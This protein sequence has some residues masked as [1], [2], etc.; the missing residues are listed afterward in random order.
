MLTSTD[1]STLAA[2]YHMVPCTLYSLGSEIG[3]LGQEHGVLP[4]FCRW[5][6]PSIV[7]CDLV[8]TLGF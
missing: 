1:C 3:P 7:K 8:V 6:L 4:K 5:G 2:V